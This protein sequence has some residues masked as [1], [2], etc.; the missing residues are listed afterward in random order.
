MRKL[1][2]V[3]CVL[4]FMQVLNNCQISDG[5]E[6]NPVPG[7]SS[8]SPISKVSHMPTF[9]LTAVGS[10]FVS[11]SI[12]VF[13]GIDKTTTFVSSTE[14]NCQIDPDDILIS[15]V[16]V[17]KS[18]GLSRVL[19]ESVPVLVRNPSPG[20]G[21]SGSLNF[22]IYSNPTFHVPQSISNGPGEAV[23]PDIAVDSPGNINVV[24][25]DKTPGYWDIYF[26]HTVYGVFSW[27]S[28]QDISDLPYD[29][30]APAIAL[31]SSGNINVV[32]DNSGVAPNDRIRFS[33]STDNG[34]NWS[35]PI[36]ITSASED[37]ITPD[38]AVDSA[39]N[40]NVVWTDW[41]TGTYDSEIY[42]SRSTDS[43]T[44]WS[45]PVNISGTIGG[46]W[47]PAIAVDSSGNLYVVWWDLTDA[48]ED[49]CFSRSTD[50]GV[51]WSP[52][53]NLSNTQIGESTYPAVAVD[54]AG[55]VNVVWDDEFPDPNELVYF[56][57]STDMGANWTS[58]SGISNPA[59]G[60][61]FPDIAID[62]AGNINVVWVG[63]FY[64]NNVWNKA[65]GFSRST[66]GGIS[67]SAAMNI[68]NVAGS[69][70]NPAIALDGAGN[71]NIVWSSNNVIYYTY[72]E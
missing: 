54:S 19:D 13:D 36:F 30:N 14:L 35:T 69:W 37:S 5:E 46:T 21:D 53:V 44:N 39:G 31:D 41:R 64:L 4:I 66:D 38:I 57:S 42:F 72:S 11:G 1:S 23:L 12:I 61:R 43:G 62:S 71:I 15:T 26:R 9:T 45:T 60:A 70:N 2:L 28:I 18:D 32:W 67:W 68:S 33:R 3:V 29:A 48:H 40:L 27:D 63:Y 17:Q 56:T 50:N 25:M 22:T 58:P 47:T 20:G 52:Y 6:D 51:S 10:N 34:S 49:I 8:I 24:W 7:L 16:S 59:A 55:N 65:L